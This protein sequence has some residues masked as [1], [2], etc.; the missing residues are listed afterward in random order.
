MKSL[1]SFHS[2]TISWSCCFLAMYF[3]VPDLERSKFICWVIRVMS[4]YL[5]RSVSGALLGVA[6][7]TQEGL[8]G[9][10]GLRVL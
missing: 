2:V 4:L 10:A 5:C 7:D 8:L 9:V 1:S 6:W 3:C